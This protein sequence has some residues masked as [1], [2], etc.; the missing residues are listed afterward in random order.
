MKREEIRI[1]VETVEVSCGS[2][3]RAGEKTGT[4]QW[5]YLMQ[6]R[7]AFTPWDVMRSTLKTDTNSKIQE[8]VTKYVVT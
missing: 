7:P 2:E 6:Q 5:L 3:W 4:G 8:T 1:I